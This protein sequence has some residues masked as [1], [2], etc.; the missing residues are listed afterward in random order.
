MTFTKE[1][2][3]E[4]AKKNLATHRTAINNP[5]AQID[6]EL[7]RIAL[8]ALEA[9]PVAY[10]GVRMLEDLTEGA[11][12]CGRVW[13]VVTDEMSGE[14]RIPLYTAPQPL[15][16][17]ERAELENY[18]NAQHVVPGDVSAPLRHAYKELT[19][20]FMRNHISVFERYGSLV[21]GLTG[22]Q[23]MRIALDLL[24]R[25]A[26]M[27]P[28]AVKDGWVMVPN[29]LTAENF[30]KAALSG[31]FY[32][33]KFI[34]CHECFGDDECETCDGSGRI[35]IKVPV[36]WTNIKAIWEKGIEHFSAAPQQE[37]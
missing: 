34:N 21:D 4:Q 1:Q 11:R 17:S 19:P 15:T 25:R 22:I 37:A 14:S 30:A 31:E 27:Q 3:I 8:A 26:A 29:R 16:T 33:T 18:R 7:F 28:G 5:L 2:L 20:H 23:A 12:S 13:P 35:E 32:E 10:I 36:S 6:A 9:E 24:D